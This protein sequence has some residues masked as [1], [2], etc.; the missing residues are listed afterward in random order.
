MKAPTEP[1]ALVWLTQEKLEEAKEKF[2]GSKSL[3]RDAGLLEN[4]LR[5]WVQ[6][7]IA[8]EIQITD[9]EKV[10][11]TL[12]ENWRKSNPDNKIEDVE[13]R[14]ILRVKPAC[15]EWS[16]QQWGH[17]VDSIYLK[18][19]SNLSKASCRLIR[20]QDKD[21]AN[22]L[23]HRIK[24][25][26]ISFEQA[27]IEYGEGPEMKSGGLIPLTK[28]EEMPFGLAPVMERLKVGEL[29][30]PLKL[31][32][33]FCIVKSIKYVPS[34]LDDD[35]INGIHFEMLMLWIQGV[36]ETVSSAIK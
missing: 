25:Q 14:R 31:G 26:E 27:A 4:A 7:K 28:L 30:P 5:Y 21:W 10:I 19:K 35:T 6:T 15:L 18:Q 29:S 17:T 33:G 1:E 22:E 16:K 13:L 9:E 12:S 32:K 8:G 20:L 11:D 2:E 3:L 34:K 36:V 23:Y 24:N